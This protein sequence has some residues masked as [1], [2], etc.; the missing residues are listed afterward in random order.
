MAVIHDSWESTNQSRRYPLRGSGGDVFPVNLISDIKIV[1]PSTASEDDIYV[2]HILVNSGVV[3]LSIK[4]DSL[5]EVVLWVSGQSNQTLTMNNS[6]G[7]VGYISLGQVDNNYSLVKNMTLDEGQ[8]EQGVIKRY[9]SN[10]TSIL[11]NQT[12]QLRGLINIS[13]RDGVSLSIR[14]IDIGMGNE[15]VIFVS[16]SRRVNRILIPDCAAMLEEF[17]ARRDR[18]G[19]LR[20]NGVLPDETTGNVDITVSSSSVS[21]IIDGEDFDS[22]LPTDR[23]TMC[24]NGLPPPWR[25]RER[26]LDREECLRPSCSDESE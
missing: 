19:I 9:A 5:D 15:D 11:A 7:F 22:T 24:L 23:E 26:D 6:M 2:N 20:I 4:D 14:S 12:Q 8:L 13:G 1:V 3:T 17:W 18:Q 21:P 10:N 16:H 25:P